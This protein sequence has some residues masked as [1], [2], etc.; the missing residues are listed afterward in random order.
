MVSVKRKTLN[1]FLPLRS[2]AYYEI[3]LFTSGK[4]RITI[5]GAA[6]SAEPGALAFVSPLDLYLIDS[7]EEGPV[8]YYRCKFDWP[9]LSGKE[10]YTIPFREGFVA[11]LANEPYL[12]AEGRHYAHVL[13]VFESLLGES[14]QAD[15]YSD[16]M[17]FA[18]VQYLY[19]WFNKMTGRSA[20]TIR[21][22]SLNGGA[23]AHAEEEARA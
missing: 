16:L 19:N 2:H 6:Y 1:G 23:Q 7:V 10:E 5:N 15:A 14:A 9:F 22:L 11:F 4:A 21:L 13:R 18:H 17:T 12:L 8:E 20:E 3:M